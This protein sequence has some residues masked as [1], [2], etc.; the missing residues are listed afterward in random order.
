MRWLWLLPRGFATICRFLILI[1]CAMTAKLRLLADDLTG[2]LDSA[3]AF[4]GA[5]D[6][7]RIFLGETPQG[8]AAALDL[9]CRDGSESA[10]VAAVQAA[11]PV[12]ESAEIAF[13]KIDSLLRGHWAA[14]LGALWRR[15]YFRQV[16]LAPAFPAQGRI[17]REG[18]QWL[19]AAR[20]GWEML[21]KDPARA[22][23]A[24]GV[25]FALRDA[26]SDEDLRAL[27]AAGRA[28][29]PPVLWCG[30][31]GLA[32]ALAGVAVPRREAL[33]GPALGVIGSRHPVALAQRRAFEHVTGR[34]ALMLRGDP[35]EPAR[36]RQA[37]AASGGVLLGIAI[38][39]ETAAPDAARRIAAVL[40]R[41]LPAL[42]P[43]G[44]LIVAGGET[45]RAV[46]A[47]LGVGHLTVE[48]EMMPGIPC[49][50]LGAGAW[51]GVRL[52]SKS[53]A[54]GAADTLA[55]LFGRVR[56]FDAR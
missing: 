37:L 4:S 27:V 10:A 15:G 56:G 51:E 30:T 18:Q 55:W 36:I 5:V 44:S 32:R 54:F 49:A 20:G 25:P 53:G 47:A 7:V 29:A 50:R 14:M 28:M 19:R 24:A 43:P 35:D 39:A 6:G 9:G 12:L 8:A 48:A 42:P 16:I 21:P 26:E 17:T 45:L 11:A 31:A 46:C 34:P 38:P 40:A 33:P 22:L 41:T 23:A 13:L 3:V 1:W 2:A 52:V